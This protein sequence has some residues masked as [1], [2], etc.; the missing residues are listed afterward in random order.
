MKLIVGLG[1]PEE[2]YVKNRHNIGFM[3]V[4]YCV[5][6]LRGKWEVDK[7][8]KS[9]IYKHDSL[10]IFSKP[11]EFMNNSGETVARLLSFYKISP[12]DLY[13]IYDD[14]DLSLGN[15]KIEVGKGPRIHNGVN[16][17]E[18]S[19]RLKDFWHIRLGIDNRDSANRIPGIDYVLQDFSDEE[20]K[21]VQQVI[22]EVSKDFL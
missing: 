6:Q 5:E 3:A 19:L 4:D 17:V 8:S 20:M 14:L 7:K 10:Q 12:K 11:Q 22:E 1:N 2:K 15:L 13:V 16:S 9:L 18:E 21:V